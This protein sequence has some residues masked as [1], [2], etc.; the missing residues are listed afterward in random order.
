MADQQTQEM[1]YERL[2][3]PKLSLVD[4]RGAIGRLHGAG[5][6]GRLPDPAD[7]RRRTSPREGSGH[8]RAVLAVLLAAIGVFAIGWIV[9]QYAKRIHAAGSLY[10]YVSDGLGQ[11][12][13][14]RVRAGSTTAARSC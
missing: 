8:R 4:V 10:D 11:Q 14:R 7:R 9:A 5:V 1:G 2:G 6:L 12:R 13:R 3:E